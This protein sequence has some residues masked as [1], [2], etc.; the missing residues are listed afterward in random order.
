[1]SKDYMSEPLKQNLLAMSKI[2]LGD[3]DKFHISGKMLAQ[4]VGIY[5][6][7]TITVAMDISR[8]GDGILTEHSVRM[9]GYD[10]P[11]MKPLK[12]KNYEGSRFTSR[13]EEIKAAKAARDYLAKLILNVPVY[14]EILDDADKY[15][16]LL[17]KVYAY[18]KMREWLAEDATSQKALSPEDFTLHVNDEMIR[19]KHGY[20]YFGGTKK[21]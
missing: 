1:M 13:D 20:Y 2:R 10:A 21:Q 9:F 14:V 12:S 6:G 19:E 4:V 5:D 8:A 16:R 11:E 15:G 7:D 3:S 18:P 17:A